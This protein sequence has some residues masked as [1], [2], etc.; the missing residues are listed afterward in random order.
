MEEFRSTEFIP[1]GKILV[2]NIDEEI[3]HHTSD[4]MRKK[5][6]NEITKEFKDN[7]A[8]LNN[9]TNDFYKLIDLYL[10]RKNID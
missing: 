9:L 1:K 5:L 8:N 3:D 2:L 4:M 10:Y 7:Y 6:D